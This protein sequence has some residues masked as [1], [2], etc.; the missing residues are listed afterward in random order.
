MPRLNWSLL[1][2]TVSIVYSLDSLFQSTVFTQ[3]SQQANCND[4]FRKAHVL[5]KDQIV[6]T[7]LKHES[8]VYINVQ[9]FWSFVRVS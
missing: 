5:E 4:E 2:R 1:F 3:A 7:Y 6:I 9:V 8:V